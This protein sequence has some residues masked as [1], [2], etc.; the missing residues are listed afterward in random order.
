MSVFQLTIIMN[1]QGFYQFPPHENSTPEGL[2]ASGGNLSIG[3]LLNAY[4]QGIFP[5][6]GPND[7]ILWWSPNPRFVLFP[8]QIKVS[9]SLRKVL[10]KNLFEIRINT[11]FQQVI[12][13]CATSRRQEGTWIDQN[14]IQSYCNL[15][16]EKYAM[17]IETWQ[18]NQLVGG[19][20]GVHLGK[21]F[22]GESMFS[23]VSNA[24]KVAFVF[25]CSLDFVLIDCQMHTQHLESMGAVFIPRTL[26]LKY[27]QQY[28]F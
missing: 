10:K 25:L 23:I 15:H 3:T 16:H 13:N 8:E 11:A 26:F 21:V 7:P 28:C 4:S 17:S 18:N 19:L 6:Y 12:E 5:W 2:L 24:S 20:Y 1:Q 27:L 22:F 9:K 14:M